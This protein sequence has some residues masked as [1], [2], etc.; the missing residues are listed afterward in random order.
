VIRFR[1][2]VTTIE[3][4]AT[5]VRLDYQKDGRSASIDGSRVILTAPF[6]T[7]RRIAI[8]PALPTSRTQAI[9]TLPYFPA[10]RVLL[11][12]G[13]RFWED[14]G[15]T[16]TARTDQPAEM[17]DC[18]YDLPATSGIL[19]ATVG[20]ALGASLSAMPRARAV[21]AGTDLV[22]KTFPEMGRQLRRTSIYRWAQDP[23]SRGAFAVFQPGQMS[24]LMPE[25][26]RPEGR[27]HFAGE[28]TS[29]WMGW[30]EG[31]LESGERAAQ[32]VLSQ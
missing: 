8:R 28:H 29:S 22:A 6:S 11:Q 16:G 1:A 17:W 13:S 19:G 5:A 24:A 23:W 30:M 20:G 10:V 3:Q 32:E 26:A 12:S 2:V 9:E 25:I 27:L 14:S 31:A 7:L 4:S 18:T 21:R 15:L